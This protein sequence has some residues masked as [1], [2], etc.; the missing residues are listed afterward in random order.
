[1]V[2]HTAG[3]TVAH[4]LEHPASGLK[5]LVHG[6]GLA[7]LTPV[8]MEKTVPFAIERCKIISQLL[9]G[10]DEKDCVAQL[11][12]LLCQ[13]D[14]NI[15]LKEQGITEEDIPWMKENFFKVSV[16]GYQ[17]HPIIFTEEEIEEIIR[18]AI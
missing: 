14:L 6:K 13:L 9:G 5:D 17:H 11:Q 3:V 2:I 18:K 15:S 12:R 4:G 16:A 10:K 8:V 1:M 7:A